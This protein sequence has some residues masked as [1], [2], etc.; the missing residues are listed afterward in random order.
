VP[1]DPNSVCDGLT[2]LHAPALQPG[3][4]LYAQL[5]AGQ[6]AEIDLLRGAT[7]VYGDLLVAEAVHDVVSGRPDGANAAMEAAAGLGKPADLEFVHTPDSGVALKS[8]ALSLLPAA[9]DGAT[10][11][12]AAIADASSAAWIDQVLGSGWDW[13]LSWWRIGPP[14]AGA[15]PDASDV[16]TLHDMVMT[17]SDAALLP[18]DLLRS[19]AAAIG[20]T[21][22][23]ALLPGL[24]PEEAN[25]A[26]AEV[27]PPARHAQVRNLVILLGGPPATAED[28]GS[29]GPGPATADVSWMAPLNATIAADLRARY[30][31]LRAAALDLQTQ[32]ATQ[33]A[34]AAVRQA[35][36]WGVLPGSAPDDQAAVLSWLYGGA[37]LD[38][39]SAK[40][41][42]DAATAALKRRLDA[43]PP[44]E[45]PTPA[46]ADAADLPER[47][48]R[49]P[50][51]IAR[52]IAELGSADGRMAVLGRLDRAAFV[53]R[54]PLVPDQALEAEWLTTVAPVRRHVAQVEAW[55]LEAGIDTG[56]PPLAPFSN[57][58]G[59]PWQTAAAAAVAAQ[60]AASPE[61]RLKPWTPH[62]VAAFAG[63]GWQ[64]AATVAVGV[65]DGWTEIVPALRRSTRAAFGFNAPAARPQQAILLAVPPV[66]R[67]WLSPETLAAII[68]ETRT[69]THARGARLEDLAAEYQRLLAEVPGAAPVPYH[70]LRATMMMQT[71]PYTGIT[72]ANRPLW[73]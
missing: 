71:A 28:I 26:H 19:I 20:R 43:A 16:V 46:P 40:R 41:L 61:E 45:P 37:V 13:T 17:P 9:P 72:L 68:A 39:T 7:D 53:A 66:A 4:S 50:Q 49:R 38:E 34:P 65:I 12:P 47:S 48:L 52:A 25:A 15:A 3:G 1:K 14:A 24:S 56:V 58:P 30:Q 33:P 51:E 59:D 36:L 64:A 21:R 42:A 6:K 73:D 70:D 60:R 8:T 23:A 44:P 35:L 5:D 32:L 18:D 69:L 57:S 62:L 10:T 22:L 67:T 63:A 29:S 27:R 31:R 11:R 2:A 55:N 54:C